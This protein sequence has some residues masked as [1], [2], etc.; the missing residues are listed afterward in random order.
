MPKSQ[1]A[2]VANFDFGAPVVSG[3]VLKFKVEMPGKRTLRFEAVGEN[4]PITVT[5]QVSPDGSAWSNTSAAANVTAVVSEV[6]GV[7]QWKEYVVNLRA[8]K[9]LYMRV[10]ASGGDRAQMQMRGGNVG[11]RV[12]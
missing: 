8:E 7:G 2:H 12:I 6:I 3:E 9:D 4:N 5:V 1:V 11:I 10:N